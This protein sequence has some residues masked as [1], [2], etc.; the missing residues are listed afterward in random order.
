MKA[1][2][3][4]VLKVIAVHSQGH[5]DVCTKFQGN[6][7]NGNW[8][9]HTKKSPVASPS[10][11]DAGKSQRMSRGFRDEGSDFGILIRETCNQPSNLT[12]K[13]HA[14]SLRWTPSDQIFFRQNAVFP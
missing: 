13:S 8:D 5:P 3:K 1:L 4:K 14:V 6:P 11:D 12:D 9:M 7:S 10:Y 2:D